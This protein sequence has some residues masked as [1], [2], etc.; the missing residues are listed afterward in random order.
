MKSGEKPQ[1]SFA[2]NGLDAMEDPVLFEADVV[3]EA[4]AKR[5][6]FRLEIVLRS[7]GGGQI[8]NAGANVGVLGTQGGLAA[9]RQRGG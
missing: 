3:V 4:L 7:R 1:P 2:Q 6:Q 5:S 9:T 8:L